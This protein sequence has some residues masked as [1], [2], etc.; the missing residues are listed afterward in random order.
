M[1]GLNADVAQIDERPMAPSAGPDQVTPSVDAG[2]D[3]SPAVCIEP[4]LIE[5][6]ACAPSTEPLAEALVWGETFLQR[7][8]AFLQQQTPELAHAMKD[9]AD[10]FRAAL[11]ALARQEA[12][13]G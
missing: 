13:R 8:D 3:E 6:R 10:G 1:S 4:A 11:A 9:A 7:H 2:L 5:G 12:D